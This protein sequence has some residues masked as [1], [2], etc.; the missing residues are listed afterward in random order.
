MKT[1]PK[2]GALSVGDI[3]WSVEVASK[4]VPK[5]TC[6]TQALAAKRLLSWNGYSSDLW[7]GVD[8]GVDSGVNSGA[9]SGADSC[10]TF[11][12]HAWIE[13]GGKV[14]LGGPINRYRPLY[15]LE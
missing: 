7:I 2:V 10:N 12:A 3:V 6:L 9:D 4:F 14:I 13:R 15:I 1:E 5:A 11:A 8:S